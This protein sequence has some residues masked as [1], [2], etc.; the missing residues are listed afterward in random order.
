MSEI[1][2]SAK[3]PFYQST[4]IMS[5]DAINRENYFRFADT[6]F[7]KNGYSIKDECFDCI[8]SKFEGHTWY[9]QAVLNRLYEYRKNI[10]N[11]DIVYY[12][13]QELLEENTYGYQELLNAYS[14][15][16]VNLLRAIAKEKIVAQ[17]NS[18]DFIS[19]YKLKNASSVSRALKKL[20]DN[21]LIYKS[22]KGYF[23]YDRFL[24]LWLEK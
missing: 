19:K 15:V 24:G 3:R 5:L 9:V 8:Y 10:D 18:G 6:H 21:E 13:I 12:A 17:I 22:E 11:Q 1:F 2:L 23:I 4:Q 14:D 16:Q 20:T 7:Q